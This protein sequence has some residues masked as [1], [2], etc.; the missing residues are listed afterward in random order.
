METQEK[1]AFV[2]QNENKINYQFTA[3][4]TNFIYLFDNCCYKLISLLIQEENY[5]K[6]INRLDSEGYFFQTVE[7]QMNILNVN[8]NEVNMTIEAL[9][10]NELIYVIS[11]G[12][13]GQRKTNRFR[14]NWNKVIELSELNITEIIKTGVR[15]EKFKRGT[16]CTYSKVNTNCSHFKEDT[17]VNTEVVTKVNTEVTTKCD[18]IL[19]NT[20]N[21]DNKNNINNNILDN[22]KNNTNFS[23]REKLFLKEKEN[24][25]INDNIKEKEISS[26][27]LEEE[28]ELKQSETNTNDLKNTSIEDNKNIDD[29][30][31][32][33]VTG[34][35]ESK[36]ETND[37]SNEDNIKTFEFIE[38]LNKEA[39]R[40]DLRDYFN[41]DNEG[42]G[43]N[44][45]MSVIASK[46]DNM[47]NKEN[48]NKEKNI[49]MEKEEDLLKKLFEN[50]KEEYLKEIEFLRR[51]YFSLYLKN[52][53]LIESLNKRLT[54]SNEDNL[55][56]GFSAVLSN[57]SNKGGKGIENNEKEALNGCN[58]VYLKS[59]DDSN[60]EIKNNI[61]IKEEE[62][63][64]LQGNSSK[65][66]TYETCESFDSAAARTAD[67]IDS[68]KEEIQKI[69]NQVLYSIKD[70]KSIDK[71][72]EYDRV[73]KNIYSTI[74]LL[75]DN[76]LVKND[77]DLMRTIDLFNET[78]EK[79]RINLITKK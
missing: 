46:E 57:D 53:E 4:P 63:K 12:C 33:A 34:S 67:D 77:L 20:N 59:N 73:S 5:W 54:D 25:I 14:I 23:T 38:D 72:K 79:L 6:S 62:T 35:F 30:E 69:M 78:I 55:N 18:T 74:D 19:D 70:L 9:F 29:N 15:I 66:A 1:T 24:I 71:V 49:N 22:N 45:K 56:E 31:K 42:V 39:N 41:E 13:R 11:E 16:K 40:S 58:K 61:E 21:L 75:S 64:E 60:E 32:E 2:K 17:R 3:I 65:S 28:E 43:N 68:K 36:I 8:R 7:E 44:E 51:N 27:D 48:T 52:S 37:N 76:E 50:N 47:A 10:T 26:L